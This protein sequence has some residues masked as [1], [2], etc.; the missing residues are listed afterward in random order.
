MNEKMN[1]INNNGFLNPS[2]E[3]RLLKNL[4]SMTLN[5]KKKPLNKIQSW[6]VQI[7]NWTSDHVL[8]IKKVRLKHLLWILERLRINE[9][10]SDKQILRDLNNKQLY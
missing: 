8:A 2:S 6:Q 4:I 5:N 1:D 7:I 3:K 10:K 9:V